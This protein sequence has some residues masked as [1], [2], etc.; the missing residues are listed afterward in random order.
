MTFGLKKPDIAALHFN[1]P[2]YPLYAPILK[3]DTNF[4]QLVPKN[5]RMINLSKQ[6]FSSIS[7]ARIINFQRFLDN[8]TT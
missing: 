1:F 3:G 5:T 6:E 2:S 7:V 4:K 8:E